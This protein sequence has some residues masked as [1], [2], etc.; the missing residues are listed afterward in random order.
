M[1]PYW[2]DPK[3]GSKLKEPLVKVNVP[4]VSGKQYYALKTKNVLQYVIRFFK[5]PELTEVLLES[6]GV[7]TGNHWDVLMVG[8]EVL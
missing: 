5:C 6:E 4:G 3:D 2:I 7:N 1:I 8:D